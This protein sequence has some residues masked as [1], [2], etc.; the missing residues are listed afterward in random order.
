MKTA[1]IALLF[2]LCCLGGAQLGARKTKRL[3]VVRALKQGVQLFSERIAQG[4]GTLLQFAS[5]DGLFFEMLHAYLDAR[6]N[7]LPEA[8]SAKAACALLDG[9]RSEQDA[10]RLF[11][12]ALSAASRS[13]LFRRV[14]SLR[15]ALDRA[16]AEAQAEAKQARVIRVSG[17]LIGAGLAIV[18]I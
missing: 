9:F 6:D 3:S 5:E 12:E 1:G 11:F 16:E 14:E 7:G 15:L 17:V 8:A 4:N 18:L 10:M 2:G 13:D